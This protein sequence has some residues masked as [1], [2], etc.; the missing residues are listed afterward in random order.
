MYFN[1][2]TIA[3]WSLLGGGG[4]LA[5]GV[6]I[7]G[8]VIFV[9]HRRSEDN[10]SVSNDTKN[11]LEAED[12]QSQ[13]SYRIVSWNVATL[14]DYSNM[15][16]I[17]KKMQEGSEFLTAYNEF[18]NGAAYEAS[19]E[20]KQARVGLFQQT[21]QQ[22]GNPDIICLQET[23]E[24]KPQD[25]QAILPEGYSFFSYEN[26]AGRDC[27]IVWNSSKFSKISHANINYDPEYIPSYNSS[28]DT[29]ALLKDNTNGT[30][31]CVGSA[32]LRGF[33]LAYETFEDMRKKQELERA[34][35]GDNQARYDL[36]T[37]D[38]V[39]ADLYIFAGDFN[40]TTEHYQPR[41]DIIRE[42]GYITDVTD[43]TT[44]IYDANLRESDGVSPK[45]V[46]LDH[47]FV[48]GREGT[49]VQIQSVDVGAT[50]LNDF[51][52]PSDHLPIGA[53]VTYTRV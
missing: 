4:G 37:M 34:K 30:T 16:F 36:D 46:R 5:I 43:S 31:I 24:M 19:T 41:F 51:N 17:N 21:F 38:A 29:I 26:N 6:L 10:I 40:V 7:S 49:A 2:N 27:T 32:H 15:C 23:W 25:L 35:T 9:R 13:S 28:P 39:Q 18:L 22:F 45:P 50:T 47:I 48:K 8:V 11:G 3:A 20:E 52:R 44:T 14:R 42:H 53:E 1:V 12:H 33:S